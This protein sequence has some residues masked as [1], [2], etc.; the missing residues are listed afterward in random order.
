MYMLPERFDSLSQFCITD[1]V[2]HNK[3]VIFGLIIEDCY[4][5]YESICTLDIGF[6]ELNSLTLIRDV[7]NFIQ[8]QLHEFYRIERHHKLWTAL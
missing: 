1:S 7:P 4:Y 2:L 6:C 5:Y 3:D 8:D